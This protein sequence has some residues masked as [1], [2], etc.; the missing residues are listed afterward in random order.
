MRPATTTLDGRLAHY[1]FTEHSSPDPDHAPLWALNL[2]GLFAGGGMYAQES[3]HLAAALGW[4]VVNPSLP[5]FGGSQPFPSGQVTPAN[6]AHFIAALLDHLGIPHVV[7][8]GHSMGGALAVAFADLYPQR[9][10]GIIYRD[11]AATTKWR[12]N[13]SLGLVGRWLTPLSGGIADLVDATGALLREIPDVIMGSYRAGSIADLIP[14]A[15]VNFSH[16][17]S[18]IP[19]IRM[20]YQLDLDVATARVVEL[21]HIPILTMWGTWD[22]L[23]P[24]TTAAQFAD[25]THTEMVWVPGGHTWMLSNPWVQ[26][27]TLVTEPHGLEFVQSANARRTVLST[28]PPSPRK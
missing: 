20:L 24:H 23:T 3:R 27:D 11:G 17:A 6:Y 1:R 5:G 2:H 21:H 9:T 28:K 15:R 7:L 25:T 8:L 22:A 16:P 13:R 19:V 10:L 12:R 18:T 4:Q 26:A 14:D